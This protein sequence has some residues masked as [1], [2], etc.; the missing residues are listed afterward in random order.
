MTTTFEPRNELEQRILDMQNGEISADEF[1]HQLLDAQ[2]FMPV[3]PAVTDDGVPSE[4]LAQP[5]VL[6]AEEGMSVMILF[7]SPDRARDFVSQFPGYDEGGM[8][9]EF[10]EVLAKIAAGS[11][12]SINPDLDNGVDLDPDMIQQLVNEQAKKDMFKIKI[13]TPDS[14]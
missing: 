13:A 5:L 6:E 12:I 9:M 1:M 8:L 4:N 14:E 7:S 2:V 11:G 3:A 10:Y